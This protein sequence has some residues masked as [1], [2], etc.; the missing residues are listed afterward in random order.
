MDRRLCFFLAILFACA[1]RR[2]DNSGVDGATAGLHPAGDRPEQVESFLK[3]GGDAWKV[4]VENGRLDGGEDFWIWPVADRGIQREGTEPQAKFQIHWR[5]KPGR[6]FPAAEV[7]YFIRVGDIELVAGKI[8]RSEAR[9]GILDCSFSCQR[10]S[11]DGVVAQYLM[12]AGPDMKTAKKPA[13]R[14]GCKC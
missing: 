2:S 6:K 1:C 14:K 4:Q 13:M 3:T 5:L 8:S 11:G 10:L 12:V 7:Y 9:D